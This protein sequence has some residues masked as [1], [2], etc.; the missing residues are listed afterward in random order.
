V[1]WASSGPD[2]TRVRGSLAAAIQS[3]H[4]CA[5]Q[6]LDRPSSRLASPAPRPAPGH[7]VWGPRAGRS[8]PLPPRARAQQKGPSG[9]ETS[10][11]PCAAASKAHAREPGAE[12]SARPTW[13]GTPVSRQAHGCARLGCMPCSERGRPRLQRGPHRGLLRRRPMYSVA[14]ASA[15]HSS[16]RPKCR[17]ATPKGP[18]PVRAAACEG[19][20][21]HVRTRVHRSR[22][23]CC[24]GTC[25]V[26][27]ELATA[28]T[29]SAVL[30]TSTCRYPSHQT[31]A[32]SELGACPTG[33]PLTAPRRPGRS[34]C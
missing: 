32:F 19:Q 28:S 1:P 10:Q 18:S 24:A 7:A 3:P 27:D 2:S 6:V 29:P 13:P 20:E 31:T 30:Q 8:R 22:T 15:Q 5:Q 34:R 14:A 4:S 33:S 26:C 16:S 12:D 11:Q 21:V 9:A 25:G 23:R 17:K